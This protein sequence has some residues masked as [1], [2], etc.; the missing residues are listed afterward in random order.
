MNSPTTPT[1]RPRFRRP[2]ANNQ[3]APMHDNLLDVFRVLYLWRK[4]LITV[5]LAV[6]IGAIVITLLMP[7]YYRATTSFY[8]ASP[9]LA[10]PELIFGYTGD[11]TEYY[12][13]DRDLDRIA[14]IANSNDLADYMVKKFHL[15]EHYDI[16][17]STQKGRYKVRKRFR[18]LF[19]AQKNKYDAL[20][21]SVED[22]DPEFAA[23]MANGARD[24][25]NYMAQQLNKSSQGQLLQTHE[26]SRLKKIAELTIIADS[27]R[28]LQTK[29]NIYN[30]G[31]LADELSGQLSNAENEILRLESVLEVLENNPRIKR[32]TIEF[33]KANLLA[34]RKT[35]ERLLSTDPN[36]PGLTLA[37]YNEVAS[38]IIVLSDLHYQS[39]KQLTFD[40][41]RYSQIKA[42][43]NT[44]IQAIHVIESA[45]VPLVKER[46]RRSILVLASVAAAFLFTALGIMVAEVYRGVQ[47]QDI[48]H[49]EN[50]R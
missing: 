25:I 5:C 40:M 33:I 12:G 27:L 1:F 13:S 6:F 24:R 8:P 22:T 23:L 48:F 14:E 4:T 42:A 45:E 44:D 30:P 29:Y 38:Q 39:R 16:D 9:Q 26:E 31:V 35:R 11:V 32:D 15:F 50:Q 19:S 2:Q 10:N 17:S 20:E 18:K 34:N 36:T 28:K 41:E 37:R 43:Y 49:P 21:V 3:N 7:N 47:W 46:P